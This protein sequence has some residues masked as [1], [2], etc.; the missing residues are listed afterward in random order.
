[1]REKRHANAF[2][3]FPARGLRFFLDFAFRIGVAW[4][5]NAEQTSIGNGPLVDQN[6][7]VE[8]RDDGQSN[9]SIVVMHQIEKNVHLVESEGN[10]ANHGVH[11][12][13]VWLA[14]L[15]LGEKRLQ[16]VVGFL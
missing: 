6:E 14:A 12:R 5:K 10:E 9:E 13:V 11:D 3:Q 7:L 8:P 15:N 1:M 16:N 4:K 2:Q